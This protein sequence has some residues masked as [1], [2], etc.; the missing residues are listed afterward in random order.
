MTLSDSG[1]LIPCHPEHRAVLEGVADKCTGLPDQPV[2]GLM[3]LLF[4]DFF[5]ISHTAQRNCIADSLA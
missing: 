3:P 2:A 4:I 1:K 5:K